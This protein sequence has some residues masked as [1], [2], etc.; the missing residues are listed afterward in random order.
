[1][2]NGI[3][4][5]IQKYM[6]ENTGI[7]KPDIQNRI[8]ASKQAVSESVENN[9]VGQIVSGTS[10]P[11]NFAETVK[12]LVPIMIADKYVN[13]KMGGA[14]SKSLLGKAAKVGD[15]ISDTLHLNKIESKISIKKITDFIKNNRFTKYF[16]NEYKAV[17]KSPL[18]ASRNVTG[19]LYKEL[20]EN[21]TNLKYNSKFAEM[22]EKQ[23][24]KISKPVLDFFA[25]V[26]PLK[27]PITPNYL[28]SVTKSLT[29]IYP[30]LTNETDKLLA[31][32]L[33]QHITA[34]MQG[35]A[36]NSAKSLSET[37]ASVLSV[38]AE[39]N[40]DKVFSEDTLKVFSSVAK[41]GAETAKLSNS[42]ILNIADEVVDQGFTGIST[43][44]NKVKASDLKLGKS[45]LGKIFAKGT[46]KTKDIITYGGGLLSLF[47]AA[48]AFSS[49]YKETKEAPK[50]E[51]L[52]TFMHVLSEQYLGFLLFQPS[53]NIM[54]KL[55]GNKYRGMTVAGREALKDLVKNTNANAALTKEGLKIAKMQRDLLIKGVDKD[56]V[57]QLAGK[58]LK[59]A[60]N[61]VKS[62]RKE[63]AK[64][65][66]W[67]RPLK[68]AGKVLSA[69]LDKMQIPKFFHSKK[70]PH[71]TL[72]GFAGGLGRFVIITMLIQPIIQKPV[73]KLFHKIFGEPKTY[74]AKR[75]DSE[76]TKK[77]PP[78][79]TET[80]N[81][82]NNASS[83]NSAKKETNLLKLWTQAPVVAQ[84]NIQAENAAPAQ[85]SITSD[86]I[87]PA[88]TTLAQNQEPAENQTN[89]QEQEIPALNLFNH[90][91]DGYIPSI[92]V[93]YDDVN[94]ADE[95]RADEIIKQTDGI[96]KAAKKALS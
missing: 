24:G 65:K 58:S 31:Q 36:K 86:N 73:T 83:D 52:A 51:K 14:E 25:S 96:I 87:A 77:Q 45:T 78:V 8:A 70:I 30:Q 26:G 38:L 49:A 90:K 64:L 74:L 91:K 47:F 9:S 33:G 69:G 15:V 17:P 55:C 28:Y 39:N 16:T 29:E 12:F 68:F 56:K 35:G 93:S 18:A 89:K 7:N 75:N 10:N 95:Q 92:K 48:Q 88:A 80:A 79:N 3:N 32:S 37:I 66:L 42:A 72:K 6:A 20:Y 81:V 53:I 82:A 59:E 23:G 60:K 63:G 13:S 40:K 11:K 67:E 61:M 71:P 5:N 85:Q 4:S 21:L 22:L 1:M 57:A 46:L 94:A 50:G 62:L 27:S 76:K 19:D 43:L 2:A 84:P 34:Y 44:R 54:Y 41:N